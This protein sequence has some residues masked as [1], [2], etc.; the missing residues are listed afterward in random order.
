MRLSDLKALGALCSQRTLTTVLGTCPAPCDS[1]EAEAQSRGVLAQGHAKST[2]GQWT[3]DAGRPPGG[4]TQ[5]RPG[6]SLRP[7]RVSSAAE[8]RPTPRCL[9]EFVPLCLPAGATVT[10]VGTRPRNA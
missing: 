8:T 5:A 2:W 3:M 6:V 1:V 9:P 10:S 7:A 4:L